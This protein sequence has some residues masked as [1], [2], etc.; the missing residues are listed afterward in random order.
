MF[1]RQTKRLN[2]QN[3]FVL[4]IILVPKQILALMKLSTKMFLVLNLFVYDFFLPLQ[5]IFST[6]NVFGRPENVLDVQK[7]TIVIQL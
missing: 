1:E 7:K 6:K 4:I 2:V 3:V 5:S